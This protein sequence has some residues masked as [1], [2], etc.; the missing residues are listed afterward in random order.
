M[1]P[2]E[3]LSLQREFGDLPSKLRAGLGRGSIVDASPDP[4]VLHLLRDLRKAVPPPQHPKRRVNVAGGKHVAVEDVLENRDC[5]PAERQCA[6]GY[7]GNGGVTSNGSQPTSA[8]IAALPARPAL[9][10]A[11]TGRQ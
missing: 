10:I 7:S 5:C 11:V 6:H 2:R 3:H 8:E 9:R 4:G 1:R